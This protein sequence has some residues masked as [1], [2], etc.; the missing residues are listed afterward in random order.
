MCYK[1][2]PFDFFDKSHD[3]PPDL[4]DPIAKPTLEPNVV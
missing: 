3:D 4:S 1:T 2:F